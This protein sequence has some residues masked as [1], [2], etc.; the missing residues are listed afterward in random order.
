MDEENA[1]IVEDDQI[2]VESEVPHK[3]VRQRKKQLYDTIRKQMEFYFSDANITKDRFLGKLIMED[4]HVDLSIFIRFNKIRALTT[5][6]TDIAKALRNSEV[7]SVTEDGTKVF[8]TTPVREKENTDDCTIYVEQLPPDA[9]H[10]WLTEVFSGYGK[11][12]YVSIPKY[13][14]SGKIKGFAF[15]EFETP[16]E[17]NKTL[18]TF[19]ARGCRL[20]SQIAPERLCSIATYEHE[21]VQ[22]ENRQ[23]ETDKKETPEKLGEEENQAQDKLSKK[24]KKRKKGKQDNQE[25][26]D[27]FDDEGE[28][29]S[30]MG[31]KKRKRK[32][33][34]DS[35]VEG[36]EAE[37]DTQPEDSDTPPKR[38]KRKTSEESGEAEEKEDKVSSDDPG[39]QKCEDNEKYLQKKKRKRKSE[40]NEEEMDENKAE[41]PKLEETDE[42]E[43]KRGKRPLEDNEEREVKAHS[44]TDNS[45]PQQEDAESHSGKK[46]KRKRKSGEVDEEE[47]VEEEKRTKSVEWDEVVENKEEMAVEGDQG[48]VKKKSRKRR[49]KHKKE[50]PDVDAGRL[51]VLSKREWKRLRNK[52]LDL[53]KAKMKCLKQYLSRN[54][55]NSNNPQGRNHDQLQQTIKDE[56]TAKQKTD[57]K[58]KFTFVPGVIVHAIFDEP[59]IDLKK[60]RADAKALSD[61]AYIDIVKGASEGFFRCATPTA[62]EHLVGNAPWQHAEILK[63]EAESQY[64]DKMMKDREEKL[65]NHVRVKQRGRDKIMSRAERELGK[66]IRFDE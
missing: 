5:N 49:K 50:K 9:Q 13:R 38:K 21:E 64:W 18:E 61:V 3:I 17:A 2:E 41:V 62:A 42:P 60:L 32:K 55:W 36:A 7:L 10:D 19:G 31:A 58:P 25:E 63:G 35:E 65:S 22:F 24:K 44:E 26:S 46:K 37:T 1:A 56:D 52:Y 47:A 33:T 8:R 45:E 29:G 43:K 54:R 4:P 14:T 28:K 6:I 51:Q 27:V 20:S 59:V 53:Q 66:H 39:V 48:M 23:N 30:E 15:V 57:S 40:G 12:A 34:Q 16:E 11:V